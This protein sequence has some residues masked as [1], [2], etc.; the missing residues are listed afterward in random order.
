MPFA[1]KN[2]TSIHFNISENGKLPLKNLNEEYTNK[3]EG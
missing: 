1:A 2:S 3:K